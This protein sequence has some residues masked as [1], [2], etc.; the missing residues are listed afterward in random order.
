ML[1]VTFRRQVLQVVEQVGLALILLATVIAIGQEVWA[2]VLKRRVDLADLL[3][4]FIYLEVVAMVG[5]Y[6]E[7]HAL[8][9]RF[10]LYIAIVALARYIILDSKTMG[11]E[12]MLAIG[13][14]ILIIAAAI[15]VIRIGHVRFPYKE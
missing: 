10:P 6:F 14:T 2:I 13:A 7:S 9:V 1:S 3:L 15:L 5:I 8:P 4:L 12:K 11:W